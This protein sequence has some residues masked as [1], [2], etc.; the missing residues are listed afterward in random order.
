MSWVLK[1]H[2]SSRFF[3]V[4]TRRSRDTR[5]SRNGFHRHGPTYNQPLRYHELYSKGVISV[6]TLYISYVNPDY[7]AYMLVYSPALRVVSMEVGGCPANRKK[8]PFGIAYDLCCKDPFSVRVFSFPNFTL[9]SRIRND[10]KKIH[11][12]KHLGAR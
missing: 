4:L 2:P 7:M 8:I 3:E 1:G 11:A 12:P 10:C 6:T 9:C 5:G